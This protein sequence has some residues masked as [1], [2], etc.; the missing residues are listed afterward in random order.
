MKINDSVKT[1]FRASAWS[2][3]VFG[4]LSILLE[5]WRPGFVSYLIP[6]WAIFSVAALAALFSIL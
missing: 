5:L 6:V 1:F 2:W 3:F 4:V